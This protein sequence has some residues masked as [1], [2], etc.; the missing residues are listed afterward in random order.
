MGDADSGRR[1]DVFLAERLELS[2]AQA[3]RLLARGAV[4][5]GSRTLSERAKGERVAPGTAVEVSRFEHP[6]GARPVEPLQR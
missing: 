6:E 4:R 3:R 1:L 2:R 5:I